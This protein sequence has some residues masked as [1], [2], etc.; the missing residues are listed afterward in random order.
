MC[1]LFRLLREL[2]T[3]YRESRAVQIRRES[4]DDDDDWEHA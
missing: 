1:R 4:E 2:Y 3:Q